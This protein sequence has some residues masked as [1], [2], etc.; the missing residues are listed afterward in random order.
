MLVTVSQVAKRLG[1]SER[2]VRYLLATGRMIGIKQ[3]N[4][5]WAIYWPLQ[6]SSGKRGPEMKSYPTR[7]LSTQK[8]TKEK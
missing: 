4:R 5:R 6:V 8:D 7:V 2:R 1:I 3:K